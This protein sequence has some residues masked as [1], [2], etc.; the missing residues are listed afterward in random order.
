M[1]IKLPR[2]L[3][4]VQAVLKKFVDRHKRFLVEIIRRFAVKDLADEH[5]AKWNRKLINQTADAK[6]AV[7]DH[8]TLCKKDL[9]DVERHPRFFV[10]SGHF[11][12]LSDYGTVCDECIFLLFLAERIQYHLCNA[13]HLC[14][15]VLRCQFLDHNNALLIHGS[16]KITGFGTKQSSYGLKGII[17]LLMTDLQYKYH[18]TC[19]CV[20]MQ[21]LRAIVNV[22]QKQVIKKKILDKVVLVEA[23]LIGYQKILDLERRHSPHHMNI[24][25]VAVCQ[26]YILQLMLVE[27]LEKL[28]SRH[29]LTVCRRLCKTKHR[30]TKPFCLRKCRRQHDTFRIEH[31]KIHPADRLQSI[32]CRL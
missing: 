21:L 30:I 15:S 8:L 14:I 4:H 2:C 24:I 25:T 26:K 11:L 7:C 29:Y 27:Y 20:N 19:L 16:D 10:G 3:G 9:A 13:V 6:G 28:T 18:T 1:D 17:F 5:L 32:Q 12:D 31:A 23:L 22:N